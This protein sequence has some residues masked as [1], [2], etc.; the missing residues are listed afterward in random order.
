MNVIFMGLRAELQKELVKRAAMEP[1]TRLSVLEN[2]FGIDRIELK[3][4]LME[5]YKQGTVFGVIMG[6]FLAY[7]G[8]D[9]NTI[10]NLQTMLGIVPEK[11]K[12]EYLKRKE[13]KFDSNGTAGV[14]DSF[15]FLTSFSREQN[16]EN[17]LI[18]QV[19]SGFKG[20]KITLYL[21]IE[22]MNDWQMEK[23]TIKVEIPSILRFY[24]ILNADLSLEFLENNIM[25]IRVPAIEAK[26]TLNISILFKPLDLGNAEFKGTLQFYNAQK[27]VRFIP[28]E[29]IGLK[30]IPPTLIKI[31][32]PIE[33]DVKTYVKGEKKKKSIFSFGLPEGSEP[34]IVYKH[35]QSIMNLNN[36]KELAIVDTEERLIG[37][38]YG[39][40]EQNEKKGDILVIVQIFSG[41][42]ELYSCSEYGFAIATILTKLQLEIRK[43]FESTGLIGKDGKIV[44][45]NCVKCDVP[46]PYNPKKGEEI[47]CSK[48][49]TKQIPNS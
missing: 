16:K 18:L 24:R 26:Q 13:T 37:T 5:L 20:A 21:T 10:P 45:L 7:F 2:I 15:N 3:Y 39:E 40:F 17:N 23:L 28:I 31:D 27:K 38:Y 29:P 42:Y 9:D 8:K 12:E 22:N 46:L 4:E 48:C 1:Q 49:G 11:L 36:F 47:E 44:D 35:I 30:L 33:I 34:K 43:R 25:I 14:S 19:R 6:D 32:K 41:K